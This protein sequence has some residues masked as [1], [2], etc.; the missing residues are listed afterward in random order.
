MPMTKLASLPS[1]RLV[2]PSASPMTPNTMQANGMANFRWMY[3]CWLCDEPPAASISAAR[4]CSSAIVISA[5]PFG[6]PPDGKIDCGSRLRS[7]RSKRTTSYLP[8]GSAVCRS[9]SC[10]SISTVRVAR[11]RMT[12][13]RLAA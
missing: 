5:S 9:P 3:Q 13:P 8:A 6:G 1:R 2:A 12:R 7:T 10:S 4:A 11:S